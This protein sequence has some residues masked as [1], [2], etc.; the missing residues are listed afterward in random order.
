MS[1]F[2]SRRVYKLPFFRKQ[3]YPA[4]PENHTHLQT[5]RP[6]SDTFQKVHFPTKCPNN[7]NLPAPGFLCAP[8]RY[9]GKLDDKADPHPELLRSRELNFQIKADNHVRS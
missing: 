3:V 6:F 4:F 1:F 2:S 7:A 5:V 8:N 9:L